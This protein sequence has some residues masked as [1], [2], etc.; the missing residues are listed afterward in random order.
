VAFTLLPDQFAQIKRFIELE[1]IERLAGA[2][3]ATHAPSKS[4]LPLICMARFG[5]EPS[6]KGCLRHAANVKALT[7]C[8]GDYDGPRNGAAPIS[9][10]AVEAILREAQLEAVISETP[11]STPEAPRW[12]VWCP[13]SGE[14]Q[15]A[16]RDTLAL[17][18]ARL[19]GLFDGQLAPESFRLSQSFFVGSISSKPTPNVA[20]IKGTRID[21]R[22]GL[23]ADAIYANGKSEPA[24]YGDDLSPVAVGALAL[25]SRCRKPALR[26]RPSRISAGSSSLSTKS[27]RMSCRAVIDFDLFGFEIHCL[28]I[29]EPQPDID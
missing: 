28:D 9:F 23:D 27:S 6:E 11:S 10:Q 2:C 25:A 14:Y 12:R 19:N 5:H 4:E 29:F 18:V 3:R 26:R 7:G 15:D 8:C 22:T 16:L 21:L 24:N 13:A 17:W 1:R 20:V